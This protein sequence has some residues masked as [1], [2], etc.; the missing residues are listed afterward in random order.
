MLLRPARASLICA[1]PLGWLGLAWGD[2]GLVRVLIAEPDAA[3]CAQRLASEHGAAPRRVVPPPMR[4]L[5]DALLAWLAGEP[6]SL[7]DVRLDERAVT[8]FRRAVH[9]AARRLRPGETVTYAELAGR[10]GSPRAARA[11]GGAMAANPFPLVVPCHRVVAAG[12]RP[13]GFSLPGGAATKRA[14]LALEQ[15]PPGLLAV[16]ERASGARSG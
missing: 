16:H 7:D 2:H 12:G 14:L 8:P 4:D 1:S 6:T 5:R 11:I 15:A 3:C 10:V 9:A 13:G